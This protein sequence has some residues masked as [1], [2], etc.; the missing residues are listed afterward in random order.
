MYDCILQPCNEPLDAEEIAKVADEMARFGEK[1]NIIIL[2]KQL[3]YAEA[4]SRLDDITDTDE[5][6]KEL[7]DLLSECLLK[8]TTAT[9]QG[10]NDTEATGHHN[11]S[12]AP[13]S[14]ATESQHST[15]ESATAPQEGGGLSPRKQL[16][17]KLKN[18]ASPQLKLTGDG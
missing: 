6:K 8:K 10:G 15:T 12:T 5:F 7:T 14:R 3:G 1:D 17:G 13:P 16:A 4:H 9:A 18:S 2:M 11:G